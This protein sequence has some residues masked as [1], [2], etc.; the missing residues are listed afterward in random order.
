MRGVYDNVASFYNL[1]PRLRE[2]IEISSVTRTL[3]GPVHTLA[4]VSPLP[5]RWSHPT[6]PGIEILIIELCLAPARPA[7]G[8]S[9][10]HTI[11]THP[12]PGSDCHGGIIN[13]AANS[14]PLSPGT[15]DKI[16]SKAPSTRAT[17]STLCA[18]GQKRPLLRPQERKCNPFGIARET[19]HV[20]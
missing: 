16:S 11:N 7:M 6:W 3:L 9:P 14:H 2:R 20:T 1:A 15:L 13:Q 4:N 18:P 17:S 10:P 5:D 12:P 8:P 19:G